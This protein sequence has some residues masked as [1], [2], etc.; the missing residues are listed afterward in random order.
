MPTLDST[1]AT[2]TIPQVT[3]LCR[4]AKVMIC[5]MTR[6]ISAARVCLAYS[7]WRIAAPHSCHLPPPG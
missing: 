2:I 4:T 5:A 3:N 1:K 6:E 7:L